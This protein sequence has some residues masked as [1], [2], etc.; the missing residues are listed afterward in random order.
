MTRRPTKESVKR[1][2]SP[3]STQDSA[4]ISP[5]DA[6]KTILS[7]SRFAQSTLA[8]ASL[9]AL[10]YII[11]DPKQSASVRV[12]AASVALRYSGLAEHLARDAASATPDLRQLT[13][14]QIQAEI[15]RLSARLEAKTIDSAPIDTPSASDMFDSI[16]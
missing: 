2:Q 6:R 13:A 4:I 5:D 10:H 14:A 16:E 12:Q 15:D 8:P 11:T 7:L 3:E 9:E 1:A